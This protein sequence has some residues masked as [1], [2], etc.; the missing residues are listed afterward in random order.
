MITL[1][2]DW[3]DFSV[4]IVPEKGVRGVFLCFAPQIYRKVWRC[5]VL[6]TA[7]FRL[8]FITVPYPSAP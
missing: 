8:S 6:C 2:A 5:I 7:I 3:V 1:S 4:F